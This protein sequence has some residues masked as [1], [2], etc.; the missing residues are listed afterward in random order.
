MLAK[1]ET[2]PTRGFRD[3]FG[4]L[5]QMTTEFD[6][7]F[8]EPAWPSLRVPFFRAPHLNAWLPHIDVF[9]KDNFLFTKVDLPGLTAKD[10]KVE[11]VDG[12]LTITGERKT[13]TE[14][15]KENMYRCEREFGSFE[16]TVPLP[17]GV[18]FEDVHATF[19]DGVLE[20]SVPLPVKVLPKPLNVE[21]KEVQKTAT[22]A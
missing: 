11:V 22:A 16:R 13:E 21:I 10:V 20:V 14:E 18:K 17:E 2:V 9:E 4:L 8:D 7:L 6:R 19:A 15:K 1:R 5:K 3:P 12:Y